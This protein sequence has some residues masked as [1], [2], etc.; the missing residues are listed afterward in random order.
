MI[1][2]LITR[3]TCLFVGSV[4]FSPLIDLVVGET[5]GTIQQRSSSSHLI[6]AGGPCEQFWRGQECPFYDVVHTAF[7]SAD[8]GEGQLD[9]FKKVQVIYLDIHVLI[10]KSTR[11][12]REG[13]LD[14][15]NSFT[16][17]FTW[18]SMSWSLWTPATWYLRVIYLVTL[19]LITKSAC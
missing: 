3:S 8:N 14:A 18:L 13:Q 1:S 16:N 11:L 4:Q 15:F 19:A 10:T 5:W 12:F 6:S 9:T 17:S 2:V 7:T